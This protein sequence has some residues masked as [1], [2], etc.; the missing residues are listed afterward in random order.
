MFHMNNEPVDI[1]NEP[2]AAHDEL[3]GTNDVPHEPVDLPNEPLAAHDE[4]IGTKD[5]PHEPHGCH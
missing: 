5:V 3:I 1:P 4:L 2:L